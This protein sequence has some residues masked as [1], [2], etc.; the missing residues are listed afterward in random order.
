MVLRPEDIEKREFSSVLRGFDKAEVKSFLHR[1]AN[2]VRYLEAE[3]ESSRQAVVTGES[4]TPSDIAQPFDS[5]SEVPGWAVPAEERLGDESLRSPWTVPAAEGSGLADP[6]GPEGSDPLVDPLGLSAKGDQPDHDDQG[7]GAPDLSAG[8]NETV[9]GAF[10][11]LGDPEVDRAAADSD[12]AIL[13]RFSDLGER[14]GRLLREAHQTAAEIR[15][16]AETEAA[17]MRAEAQQELESARSE[18]AELRNQAQ[19][20]LVAAHEQATA[21][22]AQAALD[23]DNL[24][25]AA[26]AEGEASLDARM[27]AVAAQEAEISAEREQAM[28]ELADARHQV[29]DL[30]AE[31]RAQ[32]EFIRQESEEI[33]RTKIRANMEQ[34]QRRIDMLRTTESASKDRI[35]AARRELESALARLDAEPVPGLAEGTEHEVLAQ[36]QERAEELPQEL[37]HAGAFDAGSVL[38]SDPEASGERSDDHEQSELTGSDLSG[39]AI[40]GAGIIEVQMTDPNIVDTEIIDA[41]EATGDSD[42]SE[43]QSPVTPERP[44]EPTPFFNAELAKELQNDPPAQS[45]FGEHGIIDSDLSEPELSSDPFELPHRVDAPVFQ[46]SDETPSFGGFGQ[47]A[48]T[49]PTEPE[50]DLSFGRAEPD[51]P[52]IDPLAGLIPEED[53][54]ASAEINTPENE[55]ALARLVREAMQRAV[56]SARSNDN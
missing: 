6:V 35:A 15:H 14:I 32:S 47:P 2:E 13:D 43:A 45:S 19:A 51:T 1:V 3:V 27:A 34:A 46:P 39:A 36:A 44:T 55:D 4:L 52:P 24:K 30:L 22:A 16:D 8:P 11:A 42:S 7:Q 54:D 56:D 33:I 53:P 48:V 41:S 37:A 17:A 31:A 29:S 9:T 10:S 18:A 40:S 26:V 5:A 21:V 25:A 20:E 12:D 23:A 28:T 49:E 50:A 38:T